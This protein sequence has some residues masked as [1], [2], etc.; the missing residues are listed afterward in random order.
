MNK[1]R[2]LAVRKANT[3][4]GVVN[5]FQAVAKTIV[6]WLGNSPALFADGIHS[7]SDLLANLLVWI[8]SKLGHAE[9]DEEHPYGHG[10]FETVGTLVLGLFLMAVAAG[11]AWNAVIH[12][13]H[14]E[15]IH[16]GIITLIVALISIALNESV[17]RYAMII[18]KRIDSSLLR[19]NAYHNRAD[20]LS[21]LIVVVGI[22]G[23]LAGFKFADAIATVLV[24]GFIVKLGL[25][26][27]WRAVDELTDRGV[28][29][30]QIQAFGEVILG[31]SGVRQMHRLRTRTMGDRIFLDM[32][33]L[34]APYASASEGHYIA[35][36]IH[37][38]LKKKF[39][40]IEDM[41]I[42]I[43]TE[44]HPETVPERL[45]PNRKS[46]ETMLFPFLQ[47]EL[48]EYVEILDLFYF[49][50]HVEVQVI[51]PLRALEKYKAEV[52]LEKVTL[53]LRQ[54]PEIRV[55]SVRYGLV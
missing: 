33:V 2:Y 28:S 45:L 9:P 27:T 41:T 12:I 18:A 39:N 25:E 20:S 49:R 7:F 43:D 44:D 53:L 54:V 26:L 6:G 40:S 8:T 30:E 15:M 1:Q 47:E 29:A 36:T 23:E 37:Y 16:P 42:H 14:R 31:V 13:L 22:L 11:L 51:L 46:I 55:V 50:S 3:V 32:H 52:W 48:V 19:A 24:A 21:A 34:I 38:H 10:R 5:F 4:S 35:E 17:F